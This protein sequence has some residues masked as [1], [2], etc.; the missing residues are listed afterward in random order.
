MNAQNVHTAKH[1]GKIALVTG[2]TSGI[3]LATARRLVMEGAAV[4]VTGR[5]QKELD[6]AVEKIGPAT[7][8]VRG[9]I[10]DLADLDQLF[11]AIKERHGRL[12]ILFANAGSGH[13]LPLGAITEQHLDETFRV[14]VKGTLFTVQKALPLMP[15]GSSIVINGSMAASKGMPAFS[16]YAASKAALRSFARGW[17]TDLKARRIRVNVVAPGTIITPGYKTGG[18]SDEQIEG[19]KAMASAAAP[20]G[21]TGIDDE[22]A[23]AVSFL[24]SDD[25]SYITGIELFVDGGTAQI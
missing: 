21:R 8:G 10:G 7:L 16:V 13:L 1:I 24:A 11:A 3:G 2:G 9:D 25:A 6:A 19:F 18:L 14:N 17:T 4:I 23:R 15:D 22:V 20:L 5:R 12:D